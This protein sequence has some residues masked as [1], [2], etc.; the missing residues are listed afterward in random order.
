MRLVRLCRSN[1]HY[2]PGKLEKRPGG[3]QLRSA[4]HFDLW[5]VRVRPVA[6]RL[7]TFYQLATAHSGAVLGQA[8]RS[9]SA[10]TN[11][12]DLAD[13]DLPHTQ[14]FVTVHVLAHTTTADT[15][16][17]RV[18]QRFVR[19]H[20]LECIAERRLL[21]LIHEHGQQRTDHRVL[22]TSQD[23][24]RLQGVYQSKSAQRSRHH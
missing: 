17:G 4:S 12:Q 18:T 3:S 9:G 15:Q 16:L 19:Q 22:D 6:D 2:L 11:R 8:D 23:D 21:L 13:S 10:Q 14:S 1:N 24:A 7:S 5:H 20:V